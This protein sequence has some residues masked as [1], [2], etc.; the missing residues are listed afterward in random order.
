MSS[1]QIFVF[2]GPHL[3]GEKTTFTAPKMLSR[4]AFV[5][6]FGGISLEN[7]DRIIVGVDYGTTF[8]GRDHPPVLGWQ[9]GL[10]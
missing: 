3:F 2:G 6:G 1:D 10:T 4:D 9:C 7:K 8:T 5:A